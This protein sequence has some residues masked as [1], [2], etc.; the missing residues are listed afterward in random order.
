MHDFMVKIGYTLINDV[1]EYNNFCTRYFTYYGDNM[2]FARDY[3]ESDFPLYMK[4]VITHDRD[5]DVEILNFSTVDPKI[6][7]EHY[8]D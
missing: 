3:E 1:S 4:E 7:Q 2:F 5:N 6:V 8:H